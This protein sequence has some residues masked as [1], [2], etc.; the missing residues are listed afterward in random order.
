MIHM[1]GYAVTED[2]YLGVSHS[3]YSGLSE[4]EKAY[5][6][7]YVDLS[8]EDYFYDRNWYENSYGKD[9]VF[10]QG[11]TLHFVQ[12]YM[13]DHPAGGQKELSEEEWAAV[14]EMIGE[15][16]IPDSEWKP[17]S[18]FPPNRYPA[19]FSQG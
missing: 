4:I 17:A 15:L 3:R 6:L 8:N 16:L 10:H 19:G 5:H 1:E 18:V 14:E 12:E 13:D 2:L 11:E 9:R 7:V